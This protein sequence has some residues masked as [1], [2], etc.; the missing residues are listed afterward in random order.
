MLNLQQMRVLFFLLFLVSSSMAQEPGIIGAG[1]SAGAMNYVGDLDDDT[2][3]RFVKPA[4]A[5]NCT[6][7]PYDKF[8]VSFNYTHGNLWGD[9]KVAEKLGNKYRNINFYSNVD[10]FS[11]H[12]IYR[13]QSY[14][15]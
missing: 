4:F 9:D 11:M 3:I 12:F 5:I 1:V 13:L 2:P 15:Y 14:K 7:L 10:E 6:F 8:N